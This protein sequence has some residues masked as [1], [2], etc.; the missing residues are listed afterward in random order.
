MVRFKFSLLILFL[1][2]QIHAQDTSFRVMTYNIRFP[3]PNDGIHYW[4]QR[5]PR[6][7][8]L[9]QFHGPDLIGVQ[10]AHRRQLDELVADLPEFEW[11]G[12]CRTDGKRLPVPDNEFSAILFRKTRFEKLADSTIWLSPTPN[13]PGSKG[14]DAALPR[15]VTWARFRDRHSGKEFYHFNTHFDHVGDIARKE[16][17]KLL[18]NTIQQTAGTLPVVVTGDFNFTAQHDA[19][20]VLTTQSSPFYLSDAMTISAIP[21]FGPLVT[22][23]GDFMSPREDK[24]YKIDYVFVTSHLSVQKHAV[25]TDN[26]YGHLASDH[27]PVLAECFFK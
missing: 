15:I 27:L 25:L 26:W 1:A 3:N 2:L 17:A 23:S 7:V 8:N 20:A 18:L 10:E 5:R 24:P 22:F 4:D 11:L 16:S 21:H 6:V 19:Y 13:I 12:V 9:I 14:W